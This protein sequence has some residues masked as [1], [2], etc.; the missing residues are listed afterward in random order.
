MYLLQIYHKQQKLSERKVLQFN[1]ICENIE[2][3][4][5]IL[6]AQ[7]CDIHQLVGKTFAVHQKS[8][9]TVKAFSHLTFVVYCILYC[10]Q[11]QLS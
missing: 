2:K 4:F 1:R 7:C 8:A 5:M 9:K 6:L 11:L 3:T 10:I